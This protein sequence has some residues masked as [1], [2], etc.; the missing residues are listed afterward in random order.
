MLKILLL[1]GIGGALEFFDF[2]IYAIF[3]PYISQTFFPNSGN[4]TGLLL[5][6]SIFA[7]GYLARPLGGIIFGHIGDKY[8]RRKSFVI[9]ILGMATSTL[10]IGLLPGYVTL[11]ILSPI[12]LVVIR[13]MQGISIGG[14]VPG[15]SIFVAEH[16][17]R[18]NRGL[19]VGIIFM[20]LTLGNVMGSAV[21]LLLTHTFTQQLLNLWAWRIPFIIGFSVALISYFLRRKLYESPIFRRLIQLHRIEKIPLFKIIQEKPHYLL[22]SFGLTALP[23]ST[24]SLILFFPSY[25]SRIQHYQLVSS[26]QLTTISF[27]VLSFSSLVFGYLSD[28]LGRK[29]LLITGCICSMVV[30]YI[31]FHI[32]DHHTITSFYAF[33]ILIGLCVGMVNGVY[34]VSIIEIFPGNVRYSGMGAS[35]NIGY[36]I[37]GG[38]APLLFIYAIEV[39]HRADAP[40]IVFS[41]CALITL[42]S[43][44]FWKSNFSADAL[45]LST[46]TV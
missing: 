24:V 41:I 44:L 28:K 4:M 42:I 33:G 22:M 7:I 17:Y 20:G 11:G 19:G 23:A 1:C 31:S 45:D 15:S 5:T 37:I 36:A 26:Y 3:S 10:L 46:V 21:G 14:E 16:L 38:M 2:T 29:P 39:M 6:F 35:Y 12:L 13:I 18:G 30:G 34:A 40:Y 43:S 27:L 32:I 8:G 9:S 25:L